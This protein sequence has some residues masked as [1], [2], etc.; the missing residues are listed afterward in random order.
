[1]CEI[2][3]CTFLF[4]SSFLAGFHGRCALL[5]LFYCLCS[6]SLTLCWIDGCLP[7]TYLADCSITELSSCLHSQFTVWPTPWHFSAFTLVCL[8]CANPLNP[9][10]QIAI[11]LTYIDV[12]AIAVGISP[13]FSFYLVSIANASSGVGRILTG[14]TADRFGMRFFPLTVAIVIWLHF[15]RPCERDGANDGRRRYNDICMALRSHEKFVDRCCSHLWVIFCS[16]SQSY[17]T[18]YIWFQIF[19]FRICLSIR[20]AVV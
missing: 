7:R 15:G 19:G 8:S 1:M 13:D 12:S 6:V 2:S 9:K 10:N 3:D 18:M 11:V 17:Q 20:H 16:W 14:V 4:G 5:L